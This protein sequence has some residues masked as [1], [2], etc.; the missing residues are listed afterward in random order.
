MLAVKKRTITEATSSS[1]RRGKSYNYKRPTYITLTDFMRIQHEINHINAEYENRKA[2]EEK[3]KMLSQNKSKNWADSL[4][5]KKK[6][7]FELAKKRFLQDEERRRQIDEEERKYMDTQNDIICQRAKHLLFEEQDPVKTFNSKLLYCDMLKERDYQ[8]EITTRK[9]QMNDFIEQQ[10]FEADKKRLE[11][12]D[13]KL[14]EKKLAEELKRKERMQTVREQL[15]ESKIK[16]I[17]DYQEKMIEGQLMKLNMQKALED[18][19]KRKELLDK[20]KKETE[21]SYADTNDRLIRDKELQRLKEIEEEKKI[22]E[23]AMKK[24]QQNDLRR[25]VEQQKLKDKQDNHQKLIDAQYN[26]LLRIQKEREDLLNRVTENSIKNKDDREAKEEAE[27]LAKKKKMLDEI[28]IQMENNIKEKENKRN[29]E[30]QEDME[31][32][33]DFKKKLKLLEES[34]KQ[35]S[36]NRRQKDKDLAEYHKLQTEEKKRNAMNEFI[37]LNEDSYKQLKR[38][39]IEDD[40]FIKYAEHWIQ[41]YKKQGKNINPLLLE[42]KRYKKDY[43]LK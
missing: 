38:L 18:E 34:D 32:I 24:Q 39:E 37:K 16:I 33:D 1:T 11:E 20:Q 2:Y 17:Q 30:R 29:K 23:F 13:K 27:R 41:E 12:Y 35:E 8:K 28:K 26:E 22:E 36:L 25:K 3:L 7:E 19:R 42:L 15:Q 6:N 10:F 40:D 9:K 4:E 14:A 21:K 31:Y 5:M 43:S